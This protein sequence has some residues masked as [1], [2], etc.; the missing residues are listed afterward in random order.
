MIIIDFFP[1]KKTKKLTVKNILYEKKNTVNR[2]LINA[3][4]GKIHPYPLE[5][6]L[7]F[8]EKVFESLKSELSAFKSNEPKPKIANVKQVPTI[9]YKQLPQRITHDYEPSNIWPAYDSNRWRWR[10]MYDWFNQSTLDDR[11]NASLKNIL[12]QLQE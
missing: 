9:K 4:N 1:N 7:I 8:T 5:K 12:K 2:F 3:G 6:L 11:Q 10:R